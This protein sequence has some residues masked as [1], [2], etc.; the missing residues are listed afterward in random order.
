MW[1]ELGFFEYKIRQRSLD[2]SQTAE[3]VVGQPF[4]DLPVH[5]AAPPRQNGVRD[6][7]AM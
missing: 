6:D 1:Y 7:E 4:K 5:E 3:Q 2:K